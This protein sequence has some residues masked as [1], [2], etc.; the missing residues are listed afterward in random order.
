MLADGFE[1]PAMATCQLFFLSIA[2]VQRKEDS[3]LNGRGNH[4]H[5][6]CGSQRDFD[7]FMRFGMNAVAVEEFDL[8]LRWRL[9]NFR[10]TSAFHG[11]VKPPLS[12]QDLHW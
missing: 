1:R 7:S 3:G 11:D 9:P 5:E 4:G 6:F 8:L 10:E 2:V 12:A